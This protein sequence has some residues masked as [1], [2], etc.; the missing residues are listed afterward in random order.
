MANW[1]MSNTIFCNEI[2]AGGGSEGKA[3]SNQLK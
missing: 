3:E 1:I 2:L